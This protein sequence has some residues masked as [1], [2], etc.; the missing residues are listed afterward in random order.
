MVRSAWIHGVFI[1]PDVELGTGDSHLAFA[2]V[3]DKR[4]GAV[5][6]DLEKRFAF[7]QRDAALVLVVA[8][9]QF[10]TQVKLHLAAIAQGDWRKPLA[11]S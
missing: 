11:A 5:M 10:G 9:D 7:F 1:F 8:V 6:A 3:N 4:V 2:R